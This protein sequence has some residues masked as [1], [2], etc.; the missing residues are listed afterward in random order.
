MGLHG[1][2][3]NIIARLLFDPMG[4]GHTQ[5]ALLRWTDVYPAHA[6]QKDPPRQSSDIAETLTWMSASLPTL[7]RCRTGRYRALASAALN[8]A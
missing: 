3:E 2:C 6:E 7:I 1:A 8:T 5:Q 4:G